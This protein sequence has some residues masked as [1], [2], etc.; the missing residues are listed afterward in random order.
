MAKE[1]NTSPKDQFRQELRKCRTAKQWTHRA[2]A[3]HLNC[4]HSL[5]GA[6]ERGTRNPQLR[7]AEKC[8]EAFG[9]DGRFVKLWKRMNNAFTGPQWYAHWAD[10]IEPEANA[11]RS[12]VPFVIPGL[13]QTEEYA[14]AMYKLGIV[15]EE[16]VEDHVRARMARQAILDRKKPPTLW[17]LIDEWAL[18]RQI[19]TPE[20]MVGQLDHLL[21]LSERSK[22]NIQVV[23]T[24]SETTAGLSGGFMIAEIADQPTT[25]YIDSAGQADVTSDPD[26]VSLILRRYDKLRADA[27]RAGESPQVIKRWRDKW[28]SK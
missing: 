10:D 8:D 13:L 25:V 28:N 15:E 18:Q 16:D 1:K 11:L 27:L 4:G 24:N 12:W 20:V 5:V 3:G 6:I 9:L 22:V 19:G 7:F 17:M 2:L 26:L 14:R 23:P 21:A